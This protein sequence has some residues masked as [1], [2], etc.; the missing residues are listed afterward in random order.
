[1]TNKRANDR[2]LLEEILSWSEQGV[3]S[4][5]GE[6]YV[7]LRIGQL[8]HNLTR[9]LKEEH[10]FLKGAEPFRH[11]MD[12][13]IQDVHD[14]SDVGQ[15]VSSIHDQTEAIIRHTDWGE[16]IAD[17]DPMEGNSPDYVKIKIDNFDAISKM[18]IL[19]DPNPDDSFF[20]VQIMKRWK[21]NN[22]MA[23]DLGN[24]YHEGAEYGN[25][26]NETAFKVR[27]PQELL[28]LK[29]QIIDYCDTNNA[30]AYICCN[31]RSQTEIDLAKPEFLTKLKE[32]NQGVLPQYAAYADEILSAKTMPD[33]SDRPRFF[34]D[35]DSKNPDV[36]ETTR[37]ILSC[38]NIPVEMEYVTPSG[39]LHIVVAN[40]FSIPNLEEVIEQLRIFDQ[41]KIL[42]QYQTVNA[43]IDGKLILYSNVITEGY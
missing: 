21:D 14:G 11:L 40:R 7:L 18:I 34:F 17:E 24:T 19:P 29:Q 28:A 26:A 33:K 30:R 32:Q 6:R 43:K 9:A 2:K 5:S 13:G 15:I 8:A 16:W 25:L 41:Y 23:R 42:K 36:W 39:G 22:G 31:P 37:A 20:F 1:M 3:A 4:I 10:P 38:N 35:I 12:Y 27:S